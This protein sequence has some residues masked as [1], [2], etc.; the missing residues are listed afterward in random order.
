MQKTE[1]EGQKAENESRGVKHFQWQG[2]GTNKHN[3]YNDFSDLHDLN[4]LRR[5]RKL[6]PKWEYKPANGPTGKPAQP[7]RSQQSNLFN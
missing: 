1:F 2:S 7:G 5:A 6:S 3:E 4:K